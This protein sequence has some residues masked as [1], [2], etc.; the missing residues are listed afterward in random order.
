MEN[1]NLFDQRFKSSG[2]SPRQSKP[3]SEE[4]FMGT[5][6]PSS[7]SKSNNRSS[8]AYSKYL[9]DAQRLRDSYADS[10]SR[11]PISQKPFYSSAQNFNSQSD[12][13]LLSDKILKLE[14]L[15]NHKDSIIEELK[16]QKI[17][18]SKEIDGLIYRIKLQEQQKEQDHQDFLSTVEEFKYKEKESDELLRTLQEELESSN[19]L[20]HSLKSQMAEM[21]PTEELNMANQQI[22]ELNAKIENLNQQLSG[23]KLDSKTEFL[24][25]KLQE[26][27]KQL[28]ENNE[29]LT[30]S[31]NARPTF[32][33]LKDKEFIIQ[34]LKE[35]IKSKAP[36]SRS[37]SQP[38]DANRQ[39]IRRD[40][41][42]FNLENGETPSIPTLNILFTDVLTLL[43]LQ[44]FGE[45]LPKLKK[46]QKKAKCSDLEER[47]SKLVQD[48]SPEGTYHPFPSP[49]QCWK[50]II[51]VVEEYLS[52]KKDLA[53]Q[54]KNKIIINKLLGALGVSDK[55][56]ILKEVN[57]LIGDS[58]TNKAI[59]DKIENLL[60][61]NPNTLLKDFK[62][63]VDDIL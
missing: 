2:Y 42:L 49:Q 35:K 51:R 27:V 29:N 28:T 56:L 44:N 36:R 54:E 25:F 46:L 23:K 40:K 50:W 33:E 17:L 39:S 60:Q 19:R 32:K 7:Y 8:E 57:S 3:Y 26:Q 31:L 55:D 34:E 18:L 47:L 58:H 12:S 61:R 22:Q 16:Q 37:T 1:S 53:I 4:P 41:E 24:I 13:S 63:L 52:L 21:S 62:Y 11:S 45:I 59:L 15:M 43:K 38:R 20:V 48:L 10:H 5:F 9:E 14:N 30:M 6:Q